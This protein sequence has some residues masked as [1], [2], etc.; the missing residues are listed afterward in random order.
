MYVAVDRSARLTDNSASKLN[1][2]E[3]GNCGLSDTDDE[4]CRTFYAADRKRSYLGRNSLAQ[5]V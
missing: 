3:D 1:Y 2:E 4:H 5:S